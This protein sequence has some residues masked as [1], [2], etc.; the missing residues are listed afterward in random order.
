MNDF[1]KKSA[2]DLIKLVSEKKEEG[3]VLRF[4]LAGSAKKNVKAALLA[5]KEVA[6]ALTELNARKLAKV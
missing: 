1:N 3:R 5:R 4:A 2:P 6:R